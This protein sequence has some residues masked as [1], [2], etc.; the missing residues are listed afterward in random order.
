MHFAPPRLQHFRSRWWLR[1]ASLAT[2]MLLA[3]C[4]FAMRGVTPLPF[5]T[6]YVGIPEN[7]RF[8]ADVRRAIRAASP[9]TRLADQTKD[10]DA[11]LQVVDNSRSLREVSLNAQGRVE[12]YELGINFTFRLVTNKGVAILPD[13]TLS[14]YREMPYDDQVVQAKEA[15]MET[16]YQSMQQALVSRLLRRLTAPDVNTA[17]EAAQRGES[18]PDSPVYDPNVVPSDNRPETWQT[19]GTPGTGTW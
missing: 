5:D 11:V 15:Q 18:D 13:T 8:G 1:A 10:A 3:A 19:P 9:N 16:L 7:T 17:Y 4:G 2:V 12:E 14:I 6:L